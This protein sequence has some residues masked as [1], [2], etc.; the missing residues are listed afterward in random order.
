MPEDVQSL[1]TDF[2]KIPD[3]LSVDAGQYLCTVTGVD[4]KKSANAAGTVMFAP[5]F[6]ISHEVDAKTGALKETVSKGANLFDSFLPFC[7]DASSSMSSHMKRMAL[8][9]SKRFLMACAVTPDMTAMA[10]SN[11]TPDAIVQILT[12]QFAPQLLQKQIVV[13]VG[14]DKAG[15]NR[16]NDYDPYA[17]PGGPAATAPATAA[18]PP[19]A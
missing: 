19:T 15:Q 17:G 10:A 2:A 5:Q 8:G 7:I 16:I 14:L 3:K 4:P 18:P 12:T 1:M 11:P 9:K 6:E 13:K